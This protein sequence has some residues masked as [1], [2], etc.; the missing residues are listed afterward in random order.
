MAVA[1]VTLAWSHP[2]CG[3]AWRP[4]HDATVTCYREHR[5]I[6]EAV[7]ENTMRRTVTLA[8]A[9]VAASVAL[10]AVPVKAYAA[11]ERN[12]VESA[13]NEDE[14]KTVTADCDPGDVVIGAGARIINGGG[15]V[16]LAAMV[17]G[18]TSVS[19]RGEA[20]SGYDEP[21]SVVAVAVCRP[22]TQGTPQI[23]TSGAGSTVA[24]CPGGTYL[25]GTGFEIPDGTVLTGLIPE[26]GRTVTVRTPYILIGGGSP[27]AYAVCVPE[28]GDPFF[29]MRWQAASGFSTASPR[30]VTARETGQEPHAVMSGVGG[31]IAYFGSLPVVRSGVF[32]DALMPSDDLASGTVEAVTVAGADAA[33]RTAAGARLASAPDPDA[34]AVTAYVQAADYY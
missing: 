33:V 13:Y 4:H 17:P 30:L 18:A 1:K 20:G 6:H 26:N 34:W 22:A 27:V 9:V 16:A 5:L 31:S 15:A 28:V 11:T 3:Q 25:S 2:W 14:S 19:A 12:R 10:V 23:I 8:T 7:K 32:L 29:S 21:W 24:T